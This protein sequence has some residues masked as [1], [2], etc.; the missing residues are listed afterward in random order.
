MTKIAGR[1][2][3]GFREGSGSGA[4]LYASNPTTGQRL[5]PGFIPATM[6]EVNHAVRLAS[7]AFAAYSRT[8]GRDRGAFLRAIAA[9]IES[10]SA[11]IVDRAGQETALPQARLQGETARTCAQLRLF[12]EAAEEGSWVSA[13]IDRADP[14]RKPAPKPDI[15]SLLRP[16]GPVVVFGASNFPLAFSVAGGDT[17]SA[18]ASGNTVIVKAHAAHPGTSELV[19]RMVQES[20][21]ECGLPEGVFSLLFGSGAEIGTSL[22]KHPLVKAGGF[23]GS[24]TAGRILMDIAAS[25]PE[26]IPFYAEMSSTNPV[27]ILPGALRE[28]GD[29][30]AAGLH[31]SFTMGA[32]QFC[33][34]PGMVFLPAGKDADAFKEKL[35]RLVAVS[36]PFHLLTKTIHSAYDSALAERKVDRAVTLVAEASQPTEVAGF[37]A[38]SALFETDATAFLGSDLGAEIFGPTTLL[39]RHSVRDQLLEIARSLEGQLTATIHGTAQDLQDFADLITILETKAGRLVFN[40]FPT[41]VEVCHAMVHGGPYPSTSDGRSTSV[42]SRAIFRFTRPVCYQGFPDE[43][44][45]AELKDSNPLG[46]L[47]MVDGQTNREATLP[48]GNSP[49]VSGAV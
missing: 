37:A 15:R 48:S 44:L 18:L 22:M 36:T 19:G 3:I 43:A 47:R 25:R 29:T 14:G 32:G 42:G 49:R 8:T 20:V 4:L 12:A 40:G 2:L 11:E 16:L 5:E 45:P 39:V 33:T 17:A 10:I 9:K 30:I 1:S 38:N 31:T 24:R 13:R 46:I 41:G 27:F 35:E 21:R 23:T 7:Q 26:P 34:K 28:R 6:E